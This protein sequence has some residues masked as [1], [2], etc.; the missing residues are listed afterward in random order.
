[1]RNHRRSTLAAGIAA[2][3]LAG[4]VSAGPA[5]AVAP[6]RADAER[7]TA[8]KYARGIF[9]ATNKRRD[10]HGRRAFRASTC[11]H[12]FAVR[13]AR[14][15]ARIEG[16]GDHSQPGPAMRE[17]HLSH[18]AE[19]LA[20]GY[21][22]GRAAVRGWMHSTLGHR[23][24]ILDRDLRLIAVAGRQGDSGRW[25]AIQVFGTRA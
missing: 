11:L 10:E 16:M 15:M 24:N 25:Y 20:E 21:P 7:V 14:Q 13:K 9:N 18:W 19:N 1:M 2:T 6:A 5:G 22:T 4:L 8:G 17:C 12:E 23:E 3:V